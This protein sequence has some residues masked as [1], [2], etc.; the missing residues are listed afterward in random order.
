[1]D[2]HRRKRERRPDK[3]PPHDL[4]ITGIGLI[5]GSRWPDFPADRAFGAYS[6]PPLLQEVPQLLA[7]GRVSQLAERLGLDLPYSLTGDG[8][9]TSDFFKRAAASVL[10]PESE[11]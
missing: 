3:G 9:L 11:L 2:W 5:P 4:T 10:K 6:L 1:M 7:P 8:E